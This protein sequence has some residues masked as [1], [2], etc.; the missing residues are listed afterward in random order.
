MADIEVSRSHSLGADAGR[1]AVENVAQDL[2]SDLSLDYEWRGDTLHFE[3]S[4]AEGRIV[5]TETE[6][7]ARIDL[8]FFLRPMRSRIR[9]EATRYLDDHLG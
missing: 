3:G 8:S 7:H 4:G 5:V 1:A 9:S 6:V 2:Q